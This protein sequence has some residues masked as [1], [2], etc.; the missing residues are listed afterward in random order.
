VRIIGEMA[1]DVIEPELFEAA[2]QLEELLFD[3]AEVAEQ[4]VRHAVAARAPDQVPPV[5]REVIARDSQ[6]APVDEVERQGGCA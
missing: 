1:R 5:P 2:E 6:L 4:V 3:H